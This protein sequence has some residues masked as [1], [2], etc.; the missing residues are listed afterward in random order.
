M[1]INYTLSWPNSF[2][3][4]KHLSLI[5]DID[6]T[7]FDIYM[8]LGGNEIEFFEKD[9]DNLEKISKIFTKIAGIYLSK[10]LNIFKN[11]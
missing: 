2:N 5:K 3:F 7:D 1:G 11:V 10:T 8:Y 6:Y 4:F 9:I